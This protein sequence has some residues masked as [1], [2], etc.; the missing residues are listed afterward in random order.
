MSALK[1]LINYLINLELDDKYTKFILD[2]ISLFK[3]INPNIITIIGLITDFFVL[4]FLIN[5]FLFLLGLSLFI[6]YS[7][8][9]IKVSNAMGHKINIFPI[10]ENWLDVGRPDTLDEASRN[11]SKYN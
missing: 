10:H 4:Y 7:A 1:K 3:Y 9:L 6:R 2:K 5:K 8:D 11:W